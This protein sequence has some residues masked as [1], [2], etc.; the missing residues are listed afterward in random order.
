MSGVAFNPPDT[1]DTT[2]R[3]ANLAV[4]R[5]TQEMRL[6]RMREASRVPGSK[7]SRDQLD[8]LLAFGWGEDASANA[9]LTLTD[10]T[11]NPAQARG[12]YLREV[13]NVAHYL[14]QTRRPIEP[15]LRNFAVESLIRMV[16]GVGIYSTSIATINTLA[17]Q[18]KPKI[19]AAAAFG[20]VF[21]AASTLTP[22]LGRLARQ[23][24]GG[25]ETTIR[26]AGK[27]HANVGPLKNYVTS[28]VAQLLSLLT[29]QGV[30][31]MFN[32]AFGTKVEG[33]DGAAIAT[34]V[35][36]ALVT[37]AGIDWGARKTLTNQGGVPPYQLHMAKHRRAAPNGVFFNS[38]PAIADDAGEKNKGERLLG[39]AVAT[40][41]ML[42]MSILLHEYAPQVIGQ[43]GPGGVEGQ[44]PS[45][46][47]SRQG[48]VEQSGYGVLA[49]IGA[50]MVVG[51]MVRLA[52]KNFFDHPNKD[53]L[54]PGIAASE[55]LSRQI[56]SSAFNTLSSY[57]SKLAHHFEAVSASD[58]KEYDVQGS[59]FTAD[60]AAG[61]YNLTKYVMSGA[62]FTELVSGQPVINPTLHTLNGEGSI[63]AL[64]GVF[65]QEAEAL[66]SVVESQAPLQGSAGAGNPSGSKKQ[67]VE[68]LQQIAQGL[69]QA[70]RKAK[71]YSADKLGAGMGGAYG[72]DLNAV[73][74]KMRELLADVL[75]AAYHNEPGGEF[76]SDVS[77]VV[78]NLLPIFA[79]LRSIDSFTSTANFLN[80]VR[81]FSYDR[82]SSL[83]KNAWHAEGQTILN[84]T[85]DLSLAPWNGI[86]NVARSDGQIKQ[87]FAP[88]TAPSTHKVLARDI[89]T[90]LE[91]RAVENTVIDRSERG[92]L[93][94]SFLLVADPNSAKA[95]DALQSKALL[96]TN[97][98]ARMPREA[99]RGASYEAQQG[100]VEQRERRGTDDAR[101]AVLKFR[102][103]PRVADLVFYSNRSIVDFKAALIRGDIGLTHLQSYIDQVEQVEHETAQDDEARVGTEL[104]SRGQ[105]TEIEIAS[106]K[107]FRASMGS[108]F[109]ACLDEETSTRLTLSNP[110]H[111]ANAALSDVDQSTPQF[112]DL[113]AFTFSMRDFPRMIPLVQVEQ[114]DAHFHPTSYSDL[115]NSIEHLINYMDANGV[116]KCLLAGIPSHVLQRTP[117]AKYY[118]NSRFDLKYRS[119]DEALIAQFNDLLQEHKDRFVLS[120]TRADLSDPASIATEFDAM[121]RLGNG[122]VTAAGELTL[123]KEIVTSKNRGP[124]PY[125]SSPAFQHLLDIVAERGLPLV[126]HCDRGVA[127]EKNKYAKD[128]VEALVRWKLKNSAETKPLKLLVCWA[129]GAGI[130]R[131]T[132]ESNSHTVQVDKM[133]DIEELKDILF[134]DLSWDF[135]ALD[136]LDN[137][138]DQLTRENI[139]PKTREALDSL[140]KI[141]ETYAE[142]GSRSDKADDKSDPIQAAVR[143]RSAETLAKTYFAML[144]QFDDALGSELDESP[145]LL[146]RLISLINNMGEGN[147]WFYVLFKHKDRCMFGTDGLSPATKRHGDSAYA[148]NVKVLHPLYYFFMQIGRRAE[149][150]SGVAELIAHDNFERFFFDPDA[151]KV[152]TDFV[153]RLARNKRADGL[154]M[155]LAPNKYFE[156]REV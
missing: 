96:T 80:N 65:E 120:T 79:A 78:D 126:L 34:S 33:R 68:L 45:T 72:I 110:A 82:S 64:R 48:A 101:E 142:E 87:V 20:A 122:S 26:I 114:N 97:L 143:L 91:G 11:L 117:E 89:Y 144:T 146:A 46:D 105:P 88:L 119:H 148:T 94:D 123:I 128:V 66:Q 47:L 67:M 2:R 21:Y 109:M 116:N 1:G 13:I 44:A 69:D 125:P 73:N 35:L 137:I 106:V 138:Y 113:T 42:G 147:N 59:V 150:Y 155:A 139:A 95:P 153:E 23:K 121:M 22:E 93:K 43:P 7:Y 70:V 133:L 83:G 60:E 30:S 52:Y 127:G 5:A 62:A 12:E 92:R 81:D 77:R 31:L 86:R 61:R 57:L 124:V 19:V 129:H 111:L 76:D 41:V 28:I 104:R 140:R 18:E 8:Q 112:R 74:R 118:A 152:R 54:K 102:P 3:T 36:N 107:Q 75:R 49:V 40:V 90:F 4:T 16:E 29:Y 141:Y 25:V 32:A 71:V 98:L 156:P 53:P 6:R 56:D 55:V 99:F 84:R 27:S 9:T 10:Q 15:S 132:A 50:M 24:L 63:A 39:S 108:D 149:E 130:S 131:F 115:I 136:I 85:L 38:V 154:S 151:A 135:I 17:A 58:N 51:G 14:S 100:L 103:R 134:I 145:M 37:Q